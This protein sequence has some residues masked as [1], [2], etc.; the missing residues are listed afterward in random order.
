MATIRWLSRAS[1]YAL[2]A[3]L[4]LTHLALAGRGMRLIELRDHD[5]ESTRWS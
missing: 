1:E 4:V 5:R 2:G 3:A